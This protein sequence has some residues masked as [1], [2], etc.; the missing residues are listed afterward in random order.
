M[1]KQIS[2][3]IPKGKVEPFDSDHN[4]GSSVSTSSIS[5]PNPPLFRPSAFH[6]GNT[7]SN[8]LKVAIPRLRRPSEEGSTP[9]VA[10]TPDK[11]RIAHA[12]EPCR[13]RKTKCSGEQPICQHCQEFKLT[14]IYAD[15]KRD[16]TKK[17]VLTPS[18]GRQELISCFLPDSLIILW[19]KLRSMSVF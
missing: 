9:K 19:G 10:S 1:E 14:C 4:S 6:L 13:H 8:G 12:C 3:K 11:N 18:M 15:G 17:Y 16:R 7:Q 5:R 2:N